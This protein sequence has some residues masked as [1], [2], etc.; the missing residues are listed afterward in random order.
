[1]CFYLSWFFLVQRGDIRPKR[2]WYNISAADTVQSS[3]YGTT[4]GQ[5]I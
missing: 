5:G 2:Q 1:M 4:Y 3:Y